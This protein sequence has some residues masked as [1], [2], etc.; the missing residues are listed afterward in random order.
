MATSR[1]REG[2]RDKIRVVDKEVQIIR[3]KISYTGILYNVGNVANILQQ[4]QMEYITFKTAN[5]FHI[6]QQ[7]QLKKK[8]KDLV[9]C[10]YVPLVMV[11]EC[12]LCP[13]LKASLQNS[14]Y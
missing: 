9:V 12:G 8:K 11:G 1:E 2:R 3:C 10:L 14:G 5:L 4:L 6:V 7:L 13:R